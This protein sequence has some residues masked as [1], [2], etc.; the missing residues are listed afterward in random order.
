MGMTLSCDRCGRE[1][2][3]KAGDTWY[4]TETEEG[5]LVCAVCNPAG[6]AANTIRSEQNHAWWREVRRKA[7]L[8][9]GLSGTEAQ[10]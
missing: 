10:G 3:R 5:E 4:W 8:W 1:V 2:S 6:V 7:E 9:D